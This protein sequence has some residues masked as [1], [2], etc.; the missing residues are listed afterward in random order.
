MRN[1]KL[2][3]FDLDNTL[4]DADKKISEENLNAL[5]T[6]RN[7]GVETV[8]ATGRLLDNM[9]QQLLDTCRYF[10]LSNGATIY[11]SKEQRY[12]YDCCIPNKLALEIYEYADTLPCIYDAYI[13]NH[14][15]MTRS[16][17]EIFMDYLPDKNYGRTMIARR[18]PVDDLKQF[19]RDGN[20]EPQKIQYFFMDLD[21]R[22][23]QIK[24]LSEKFPCLYVSTSL[25][26]NIE[27]N[28][29][30]AVKGNALR[31]MCSILNIPVSSSVAFGD[32]TND[33]SMIRDAGIG[34]SMSNG[35][36]ECL[37]IA[38]LI[39]EFDCNN[40]GLGREL[41]KLLNYQ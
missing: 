35:A 17:H 6:A 19:I 27:I 31:K 32:G 28:I 13:N 9:P 18:S 38:D 4:L 36:K 21:E 7:L 11:D 15:Y 26:S 8:P 3:A 20:Y 24:L 39:T 10:I 22:N 12:L 30:D 40:S 1:I 23:R 33:L 2:V 5:R 34:V 16:M 37:E 29:A 25:A 14:G 41:L